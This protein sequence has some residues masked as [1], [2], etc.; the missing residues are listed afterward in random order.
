MTTRRGT[1]R[2]AGRRKSRTR[3]ARL[4]AFGIAVARGIHN[5][6]RLPGR[7]GEAP[8]SARPAPDMPAGHLRETRTRSGGGPHRGAPKRRPAGSQAGPDPRDR[9]A[10]FRRVRSG[11]AGSGELQDRPGSRGPARSCTSSAFERREGA[12]G[13]K[14]ESRRPVSAA[15][16]PS[17]RAWP[18]SAQG[19]AGRPGAGWLWRLPERK[20]VKVAAT[21]LASRMARVVRAMTGSSD[22]CR[23]AMA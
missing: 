23:A 20:P 9:G 16:A 2:F 8:R 13:T 21:A 3:S 18:G 1:S 12:P 15:S 6:D 19:G 10:L 14:I 11:H 7:I 4:A 22:S 5:V 17:R